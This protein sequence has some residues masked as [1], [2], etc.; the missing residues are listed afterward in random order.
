MKT[1]F[2]ETE[3]D[4]IGNIPILKVYLSDLKEIDNFA[5]YFRTFAKTKNLEVIKKEGE[6][7][8]I[9]IIP[10]V[11]P[12]K[13]LK[14]DVEETLLSD[15]SFELE[16][17]G[18]LRD[19]P[20]GLFDF[21]K[22]KDKFELGLSLANDACS[23]RDGLDNMRLCLELLVKELLKNEKSLENQKNGICNLLS[24]KGYSSYI[25][26]MFIHL[27]DSYT[28]YQNNN[29]KH[30]DGSKITQIDKRFII[31]QTALF[32]DVLTK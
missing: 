27:L 28:K 18:I 16:E 2:F 17:D 25:I 32:I 21:P 15:Y 6:T 31:K 10:T 29:V 22:I 30:D 5:N 26:S 8:Y 19:T 4:L 7:P 23:V 24:G 3:I 12:I 20:I 14:D 1:R 13:E 11:M 9:R